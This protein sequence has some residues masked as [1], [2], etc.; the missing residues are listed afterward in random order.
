M[1]ISEFR[2]DLDSSAKALVV[3]NL[4][5]LLGVV[6]L[7]WDVG[8]IVF[9]YWSENVIVGVYNVLNMMTS[10]LEERLAFVKK[11]FIS[12]FF[13]VHYGGF[14]LGHGLAVAGSNANGHRATLLE[15]ER[16]AY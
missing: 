9:V 2:R 15:V 14:C 6:F 16:A 13:C 1:G 12:G 11:L 8:A 7:G 3:A 4:V 10:R 5:P